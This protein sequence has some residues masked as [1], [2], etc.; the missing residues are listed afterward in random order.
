MHDSKFIL[1][2]FL[3]SWILAI[4]CLILSGYVMSG[5]MDCSGGWFDTIP[6]PVNCADE[7]TLLTVYILRVFTAG[8]LLLPLGLIGILKIREYQTQKGEKDRRMTDIF[9]T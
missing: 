7:G 9:R 4:L 2:L 6:G 5:Y 3:P 1:T 8:F